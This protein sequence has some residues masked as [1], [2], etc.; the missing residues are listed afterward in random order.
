MQKIKKIS[1]NIC[2]SQEQ[3]IKF[4]IFAFTSLIVILH[5]AP[6]A[7]AAVSDLITKGWEDTINSGIGDAIKDVFSQNSAIYEAIVTN[8]AIVAPIY[9]I[10]AGVSVGVAVIFIY[11]DVIQEVL[12]G[13][14]KVECFIKGLIKGIIVLLLVLLLPRILTELEK[15]GSALYTTLTDAIK[16]VSTDPANPGFQASMFST[17]HNLLGFLSR[18]IGTF[19]PWLLAQISI[20]VAQ[21]VAY[22]ILIEMTIR[23]MFSPL[24]IAATCMEGPRGGGLRWF[25]RYVA[26]YIRMILICTLGY[27]STALVTV[28]IQNLQG[29]SVAFGVVVVNFTVVSLMIKSSELANEIMSA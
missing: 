22:S 24:A 19:F 13:Q 5:F 15:L 8:N 9:N 10:L 14:D 6:F 27:V 29:V 20:I 4:L 7:H 1:T 16:D 23:K 17:K 18:V 21:V 12:H 28:I 3:I 25:R 2:F 11:I 26:L